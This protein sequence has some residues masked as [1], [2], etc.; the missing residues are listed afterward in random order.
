MKRYMRTFRR[1]RL[2]VIAPVVLTLVI[3][4]GYVF[5]SPRHYSAQGT[6]WADAPVP[7]GTTVFSAN[8]PA[9]SPATQDASF[10]S[11]LL[12]TDQFLKALAPHTPWAAYVRQHPGQL[13]NVFAS[14]QKDTTVSV[15]GPQVIGVTYQANDSATAIPMARALV[16]TFVAQ[17]VSLQRQRDQQQ[18]GYDN[19]SVQTTLSALNAAQKQLSQYLF[20][21]PQA[22]AATVDPT[23]TQLSGNVA[24]AQQAYGTAIGNL[25]ASQQGLST[26][27]DSSQLHVIDQP[28]VV[29]SQSRKK[30]IVYGGVGGLFAGAL[31]SILL[32]SWLVSRET[33]PW[34]AD[35]VE[36]D[37]GL[38][39]VGSIEQIPAVRRQ[40]RGVS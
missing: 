26:V 29:T 18:I 21:H 22:A 4:L 14:L 8:P 13:D 37:L 32:L 6:L 12:V 36:D 24:T 15:L 34:D 20:A 28:A 16:N 38:T 31:I 11:E 17:A 5:A 30:K 39:V 40:N 27:A 19:Q 23:V 7:N 33:A 2:L 35:D 25:N 1:H 3:G 9:Q 10:F